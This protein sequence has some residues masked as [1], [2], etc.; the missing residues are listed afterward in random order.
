MSCRHSRPMGIV[1]KVKE[2]GR[3]NFL[4][5]RENNTDGGGRGDRRQWMGLGG[6]DLNIGRKYLTNG[7][8]GVYNMGL[9][10]WFERLEKRPESGSKIRRLP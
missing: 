5:R 4:A 7:G 3:R 2:A 6:I 10:F 8:A 1:G 9:N